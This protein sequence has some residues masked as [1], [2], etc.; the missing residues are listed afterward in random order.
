MKE[1]TKL[2][3]AKAANEYAQQQGWLKNGKNGVNPL[4]RVSGVSAG[5]LSRMLAGQLSYDNGAVISTVQWDKLA[6][7]VGYEVDKNVWPKRNTA[8]F[9]ATIARL[10]E[11]KE[12]NIKGMVIGETGSGKTYTLDK[13]ARVNPKN[14]IRI[15]LS[16]LHNVRGLLDDLCDALAVERRTSKTACLK[17]ITAKVRNIDTSEHGLL[18]V[19]DEAENATVPVLRTIKAVYDHI[20]AYCSMMLLGTPQLISNLDKMTKR[21]CIGIPQFVSRFRANTFFLED[22]VRKDPETGED[23][24][25]EEFFAGV[26]KDEGLKALLRGLCS[27]YRMLRDYLVPAIERAEAAGVELT[28]DFFRRIT[29]IVH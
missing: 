25:F 6:K 1:T 15:T 26:V 27:D 3:I 7:A 2:S 29:G 16:V 21:D 10:E 22:I 20:H 19:F 23:T 5:Y 12:M 24:T 13:F 18:I 8:Q 9:I 11:A 28:E 4:S 17:A 14:T